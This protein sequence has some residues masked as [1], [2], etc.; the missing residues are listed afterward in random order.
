MST[1]QKTY[2]P[3]REDGQVLVVPLSFFTRAVTDME[4]GG[5][6]LWRL[7]CFLREYELGHVVMAHTGRGFTPPT[8]RTPIELAPVEPLRCLLGSIIE[9]GPLP[10]SAFS[11]RIISRNTATKI[12]LTDSVSASE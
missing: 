2:L 8:D 10:V 1:K 7:E 4:S 3:E 6:L 9:H 5:E 12:S 11:G